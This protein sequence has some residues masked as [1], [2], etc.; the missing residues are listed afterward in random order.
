MSWYQ[1]PLVVTQNGVYQPPDLRL[2]VATLF[3]CVLIVVVASIGWGRF[4][5]I[6]TLILLV[7]ATMRG[8]WIFNGYRRFGPLGRPIVAVL[9]AALIFSRPEDSRGALVVPLADLQHVVVYGRAGRRTYRFV[10]TGN[11]G[12]EATPLWG[13]CI[14]E[15]VLE[16]LQ[17][18]LPE[19]TT[20]EEPQT[21]F[22][23]VRGDGPLTP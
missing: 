11:H 15:R 8:I 21:L 3:V 4:S 14:E 9:K 1:R 10:Q 2:E 20:V 6:S 23:A 17:R 12:E 18:A 19:R 13:V 22:A 16:F 7:L 5:P